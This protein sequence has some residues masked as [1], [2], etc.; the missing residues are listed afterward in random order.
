M[1][2]Q[3]MSRY[4]L[5]V[6]PSV[7][8]YIGK[9]ISRASRHPRVSGGVS[10]GPDGGAIR[11]TRD[12]LAQVRQAAACKPACPHS[13]AGTQEPGDGAVADKR[14]PRAAKEKN[15]VVGRRNAASTRSAQS[16]R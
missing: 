13:S 2:T 8:N 6:A 11:R 15:T 12:A 1:Y 7:L 4:L 10:I 5:T 14:P 16:G 9:E 3:S